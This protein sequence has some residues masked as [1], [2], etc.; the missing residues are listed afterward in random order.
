MPLLAWHLLEVP[1]EGGKT[2]LL[3]GGPRRSERRRR[4][5]KTGGR[6]GKRTGRR[7]RRGRRRMVRRRRSGPEELPERDSGWRMVG[8]LP[9]L[10]AA[11]RLRGGEGEGLGR[12]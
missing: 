3:L 8:V 11:A 7:R 9:A 10:D 1:R 12:A 4:K 2:L 5:R 6:T